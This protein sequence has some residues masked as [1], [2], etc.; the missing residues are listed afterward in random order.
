VVLDV[1]ICKAPSFD[2]YCVASENK[3][4]NGYDMVTKLGSNLAFTEQKARLE[5]HGQIEI[6]RQNFGFEPEHGVN[7]VELDLEQEHYYLEVKK[8]EQME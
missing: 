1:A 4:V 7:E 3:G 2:Y 8:K 6:V 5:D